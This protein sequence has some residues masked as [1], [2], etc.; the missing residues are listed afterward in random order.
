MTF[1]V[2]TIIFLPLSFLSSLFALDVASFQQAPPWALL[3]IF[4]VSFAISVPLASCVIWWEQLVEYRQRQR[5]RPPKR[6][7]WQTEPQNDAE[8]REYSNESNIGLVKEKITDIMKLPTNLQFR[9]PRRGSYTLEVGII[10]SN[11]DP[12][13]DHMY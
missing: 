1:T 13:D 7:G 11:R 2:S 12:E 6:R 5:E 8:D 9:Q 3:T 4:L 10:T